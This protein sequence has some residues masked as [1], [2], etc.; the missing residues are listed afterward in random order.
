ML[1]TEQKSEYFNFLKTSSP[2]EI[3]DF[4]K[5]KNE[6]KRSE[7]LLQGIKNKPILSFDRISV[8]DIIYEKQD[9]F[10]LTEMLKLYDDY[11]SRWNSNNHNSL[12]VKSILENNRPFSDMFLNEFCLE[13]PFDR[14]FEV[15]KKIPIE[16]IDYVLD[17]EII[18]STYFSKNTFFVDNWE[19]S[20]LK[21]LNETVVFTDQEKEKIRYVLERKI[22]NIYDILL[23]INQLEFENKNKI[24]E[25]ISYF[26]DNTN[27][28]Y[29]SFENTENLTN[30]ILKENPKMF[31]DL[32]KEETI[33]ID[34]QNDKGETLWEML[35][36][37]T[38]N[39][40][41]DFNSDLEEMKESEIEKRQWI[42][43]IILTN[44]KIKLSAS[45]VK[46]QEKKLTK[47]L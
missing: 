32:L 17:N 38:L 30:K 39:K 23:H 34:M 31:F 36:K 12:Y 15:I 14:A 24:M 7:Y 20:F 37:E 26:F 19:G 43:K 3:L 1:S 47:R 25:N 5:S 33:P 29:L 21:D 40:I 6:K 42:K 4:L 13:I 46:E 41:V 8:L 10:L 45:I 2:S 11:T 28:F 18:S 44:D 27:V 35:D 16:N 22:E 9:V